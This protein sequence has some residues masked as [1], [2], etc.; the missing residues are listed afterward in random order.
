LYR[1]TQKLARFSDIVIVAPGRV[2]G[3]ET[4][5]CYIGG[6]VVY[7]LTFLLFDILFAVGL[8]A[9]TNAWVSFVWRGSGLT[10]DGWRLVV[11]GLHWMLKAGWPTVYVQQ[12][13]ILLICKI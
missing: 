10:T 12:L 5:P 8:V 2:N 9:I 13:S 1:L 4:F 6:C 11:G 3:C 7:F